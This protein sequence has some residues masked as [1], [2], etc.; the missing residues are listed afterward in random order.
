VELYIEHLQKK[1]TGAKI[2]VEPLVIT[3]SLFVS[4]Q[5]LH[6]LLRLYIYFNVI[7]E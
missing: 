1:P 5:M 3:D 4:M 6:T 2:S 7:R